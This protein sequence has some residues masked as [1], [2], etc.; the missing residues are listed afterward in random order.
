MG[1]PPYARGGEIFMATEPGQ[2]E[3]QP[4]RPT[5]QEEATRRIEEVTRRR[6][7]GPPRAGAGKVGR[8]GGEVPP[9]PPGLGEGG[10]TS[11]EGTPPQGN[12]KTPGFRSILERLKSASPGEIRELYQEAYDVYKQVYNDLFIKRENLRDQNVSPQDPRLTVIED[13]LNSLPQEKAFIDNLLMSRVDPRAGRKIDETESRLLD[14]IITLDERIKA[15]PDEVAK[16]PLILERRGKIK[17]IMGRLP[18]PEDEP[19]PDEILAAI[20]KDYATTQEFISRI[21][22]PEQEDEAYQLKGF[23]SSVNKDK[24]LKVTRLQRLITGEDRINLETL[25]AATE[26][27]HNMNYIMKR[28]F[29]QFVQQSQLLLPKHFN[30]LSHLPGVARA[31]QIYEE[32][33]HR[34]I[35]N[36][37]RIS[38]EE[39][40]TIEKDVRS[41]FEAEVS[42]SV[43]TDNPDEK[44]I[45][46][47]YGDKMQDWEIDRA[48]IYSRNFFRIV[49]APEIISN[50]ELPMKSDPGIFVS[51]P[52]KELT[53]LLHPLKFIGF[54]FRPNLSR[55][56]PE[57]I[58]TFLESRIKDRRENRGVRL[59]IVEGTDVDMRELKEAVSARMVFATW[60]NASAVLNEIK[61]GDGAKITD[62]KTFYLE[63]REKISNFTTEA[64]LISEFA[65]KENWRKAAEI[66][67]F[68]GN[69]G[70]VEARIKEWKKERVQTLFS[71]LIDNNSLALGLIVSGNGLAFPEELKEIIWEKVSNLDPLTMSAFLTRLE[72]DQ[73]HSAVKKAQQE[74]RPF[75]V[76]SLE[77]IIMDE[78]GD[79]H[80]DFDVMATRNLKKRMI[81]LK[82]EKRDAE[83]KKDTGRT[84]SLSEEI[85]RLSV[86]YEKKD[87]E[88]QK[89]L[90]D[91]KW[92]TLQKKLR[93]LNSI[94]I[95][96][97]IDRLKTNSLDTLNRKT[98]SNIEDFYGE[99]GLN[100]DEK[101][102]IAQ[103]QKNGQKIAPDL[104]RIKQVDAWFLN[105]TPFEVIEW[106]NLGQYFDR[107][108]GDLAKFSQANGNYLK[109]LGDPF[110]QKTEE[111]IK[112]VGEGI[113]V[114]GDVLGL[115][116][117]QKN[118]KGLY[119][120]YLDMIYE[121]PE[122][123]QKIISALR[124]GAHKPTSRAQEF[125]GIHGP[126]V[127]EGTMFEVVGHSLQGKIFS[128]PGKYKDLDGWEEKWE[129]TYGEEVK[130]LKLQWWR[131]MVWTN[132]RDFGPFGLAAFFYEFFKEI[133]R[134][135]SSE[136]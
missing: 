62:V 134:G 20:G 92:K 128:L 135:I 117:A 79:S 111:I 90:D 69:M 63:N 53:Q 29:D 5:S 4:Q 44:T 93:S 104:A 75:Q 26:T 34:E 130:R 38:E 35:G 136:K 73:E 52:Q 122:F 84:R 64:K 98:S 41:A 116:S 124:H 114:A 58:Q 37:T 81:Q 32:F 70:D 18:S 12:I 76:K 126:S 8:D 97:E 107:E 47:V 40:D 82:D 88:L 31:T 121:Y 87:K 65:K 74:G 96:K 42:A 43:V 101:R 119:D 28:S 48:L 7:Q 59:K 56:G 22:L 113:Q 19:I 118:V 89:V 105:D 86:E 103:I 6:E 9:T 67:G 55:G 71:S 80:R 108:T 36:R 57:M 110:G 2:G 77:E 23:Y 51:S 123:R 94:R 46:G 91:P 50:S 125:V 45:K 54:R 13:T 68:K 17:E 100:L 1:Q 66:M 49:R 30:V 102:V 61:F 129:G 109:W 60:R 127:D 133:F 39:L 112:E 10:Q 120:V 83:D 131:R 16:S 132:F 25:M 21:I 24:F 33:F 72:V 106:K 85:D 27:F 115:D 78:W 3:T 14:E 99:V 95:N 15:A 11:E